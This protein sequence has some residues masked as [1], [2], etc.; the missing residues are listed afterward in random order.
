MSVALLVAEAFVEP[1]NL[2]CD[3]VVVLDGNFQNVAA[4]NL[5]W[6]PKWFAW[7]YTHQLKT[8][9]PLHYC[10]LPVVNIDTDEEHDSIIDAGIKY[11]L[12]FEDVWRSTFSG[13]PIYPY[14]ERYEILERV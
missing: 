1:D 12:L 9:Q 10:N 7:K 13:T 4:E 3:Q 8:R 11:G 14:R 5:R 2:L 6:R